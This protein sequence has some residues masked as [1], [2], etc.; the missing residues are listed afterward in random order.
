MEAPNFIV[1]VETKAPGSRTTKGETIR[2]TDININIEVRDGGHVRR[3]L[4]VWG[5]DHEGMFNLVVNSYDKD[6]VK[7]TLFNEGYK[8]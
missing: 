7:D 8:G 1:T 3:V 5:Y 2:S 6:G 4:R